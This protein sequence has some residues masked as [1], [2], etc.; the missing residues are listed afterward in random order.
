MTFLLVIVFQAYIVFMLSY[1]PEYAKAASKSVKVAIIGY[2]RVHI[3]YLSGLFAMVMI[4]LSLAHFTDPGRVANKWP[5][6]P[7]KTRVGNKWSGYPTAIALQI[8]RKLDGSPRYCRLCGLYKPDRTHHCRQCGKCTLAMDHHCPYLRNCIGFLNYK[9]FFLLLFYGSIFLVSFVI[10]MVYKFR[11]SVA[12]PLFLFDIFMIFT[13]FLAIA[14]CFVILPFFGLHCWLTYNAYTTVEFCE[15]YRAKVTKVFKSGQKVQDVYKTS[16]FQKGLYQNLCYTLGPNPLFWLLPVRCGMSNN[17]SA[18]KAASKPVKQY[19]NTLGI[20][21]PENYA[22][23]DKEHQGVNSDE[24]T[25]GV[26]E[27][28]VPEETNEAK[29]AVE[30]AVLSQQ[31][32][33]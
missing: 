27:F 20:K 26:D 3:P 15:K 18:I 22:F 8:E 31:Q 5:W 32:E 28:G 14:M 30:K 21:I 7:A 2:P 6:D 16:L 10:L 4:T 12:R 11:A 33:A 17:G 19:F 1:M 24:K 29:D 9:Y 23:S 25:A 13:W